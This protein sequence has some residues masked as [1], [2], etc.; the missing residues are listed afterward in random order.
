MK[1]REVIV[2]RF[3]EKYSLI[4]HYT[5]WYYEFHIFHKEKSMIGEYYFLDTHSY[6]MR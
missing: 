6:V 5:C 1:L 4:I 3:A 2:Y